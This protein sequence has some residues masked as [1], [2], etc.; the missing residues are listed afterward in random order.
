MR[1]DLGTHA[2]DGGKLCNIEG[3]AF[4]NSSIKQIVWPTNNPHEYM[5]IRLEDYA[6]ANCPSLIRVDF[7]KYT[8]NPGAGLTPLGKY[9]FFNCPSLE[10]VDFT[11][12]TP[13]S[14]NY[15]VLPEGLFKDCIGLK[16]VKFDDDKFT[17]IG[18]EA[19]S[20]C[21]LQSWVFKNQS[22]S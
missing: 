1:L 15:G 8:S 6:M 21:N 11:G 5:S 22:T 17:E 19:F 18:D 3:N 4:Y 14:G 2:Y 12:A 13:V 9:A 10:E 20:N 16:N 7:P